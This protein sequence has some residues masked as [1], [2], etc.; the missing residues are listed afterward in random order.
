[1]KKLKKTD[2]EKDNCNFLICTIE[3]KDDCYVYDGTIRKPAKYETVVY[4]K[5]YGTDILKWPEEIKE[6]ETEAEALKG[7]EEMVEKWRAS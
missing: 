7:H 6:Y 4:N 5:I 3:Y 2:I 1:M